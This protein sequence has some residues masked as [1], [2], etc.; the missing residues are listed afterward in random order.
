VRPL[1]AISSR[2]T[3]SGSYFRP[4]DADLTLAGLSGRKHEDADPD[5]F[6]EA[7]D[8]DFINAV[9]RRLGT[10]IPALADAPY[11]RGH[12]GI[13]DATPDRCLVLDK[14]PGIS[15]LY[16][17]AGF[18]GTGFKTAPMVAPAMAELIITARRRPPICTACHRERGSR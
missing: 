7:N 8:P 11:A 17:A 10:R 18:S 5:H 1:S 12:A 14:I 9:R 16:V 15:G 6:H 3:I 4:H 13:Y 2:S